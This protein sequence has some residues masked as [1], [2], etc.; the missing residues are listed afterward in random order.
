MTVRRIMHQHQDWETVVFKKRQPP[1]T[2]IQPRNQTS[3]HHHTSSKPT[4]TISGKPAW[5]IEELADADSGKPVTY[6]SRQDAQKIIQ[7][8]VKAKLKQ[9]ELATRLNIPESEIKAIE[10][11]KAIENK[12]TI[13][14]ILLE[15]NKING[16]Q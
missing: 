5:K 9:G 4:Q 15:L 16:F 13:S 11:C 1:K 14:R 7:G 3:S 12:K 10:S 2:E 8:R 6:V